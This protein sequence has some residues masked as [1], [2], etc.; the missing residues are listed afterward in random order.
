[1]DGFFLVFA[2]GVPLLGVLC[3]VAIWRNGRLG[4]AIIGLAAAGLAWPVY[5]A[6][7]PPEEF[8][9]SAIKNFANLTIPA[10][11]VFLNKEASFPDFT[12]DYSA[13]FVVRLTPAAMAEFTK[14][15]GKRQEGEGNAGDCGL[16][17]QIKVRGAKVVGYDRQPWSASD[18]GMITINVVPSENLVSV[19]WTQ[20]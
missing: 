8:Y 19:S 15:L 13:C 2:V 16:S 7:Y 6:L 1:M 14:Q 17:R 11:A 10:N 9:V 12:G 3:L 18:S 4:K 5:Q 20:A